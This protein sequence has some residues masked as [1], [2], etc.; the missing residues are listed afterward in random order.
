MDNYVQYWSDVDDWG[1][2]SMPR[3]GWL[4]FVHTILHQRQQREGFVRLS[5]WMRSFCSD[6]ILPTQW[7]ETVFWFSE[8][9]LEMSKWSSI[10]NLSYSALLFSA[11]ASLPPSTTIS[12][13]YHNEMKVS[14]AAAHLPL[15]NQDVLWAAG[16]QKCEYQRQ[17]YLSD[18]SK[19][20]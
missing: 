1:S 12:F 5:G 14:Q 18:F 4:T 16:V 9:L 13:N 6:S 10:A 8:L 17:Y 15:V 19:T 20:L 2:D 3:S 7:I 11:A